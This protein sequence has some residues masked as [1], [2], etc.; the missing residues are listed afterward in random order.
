[1]KPFINLDEAVANA[2]TILPDGK[3]DPRMRNLFRQWVYLGERQLGFSG[4]HEKVKADI[5]AENLSITKPV[6]YAIGIDMA[7]F[8]SNGSEYLWHYQAYSERIHVASTFLLNPAGVAS[9]SVRYKTKVGVGETPYAF[10]L[11]TYGEDITTANLRYYSYPVDDSGDLLIPE[12]HLFALM[13]FIRWMFYT[14]EG[15][16][17]SMI[18][19]SR[20]QWEIEKVKAKTKNKMPSMIEGRNLARHHN[21]LI[22]KTFYEKY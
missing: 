5:P 1:M 19:E 13:F 3:V 21:S 2:A 9:S 4:L 18:A 20:Q 15:K 14:R 7:L 10:K 11:D 8:D 16:D 17:K 22:N 6:D 12:H